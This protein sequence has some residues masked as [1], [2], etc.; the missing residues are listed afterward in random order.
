MSDHEND[1]LG[2]L[3]EQLREGRIF[4]GTRDVSTPQNAA[5]VFLRLGPSERAKFLNQIDSKLEFADMSVEKAAKLHRY[6]SRLIHAHETALKV[7]R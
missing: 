7:K 4:S 1:P 2:F 6:R 3:N 5:D